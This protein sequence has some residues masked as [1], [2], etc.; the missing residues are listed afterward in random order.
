MWIIEEGIVNKMIEAELNSQNRYD[1]KKDDID[2]VRSK[3]NK[4]LKELKEIGLNI[5]ISLQAL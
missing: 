1:L 5:N 3:V 4:K 2:N